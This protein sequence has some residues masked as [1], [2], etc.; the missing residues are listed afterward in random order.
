MVSYDRR[1]WSGRWALLAVLV[2]AGCADKS[3]EG[4]ADGGDG[5]G[6]AAPYTFATSVDGSVPLTD[7]TAAQAMQF[8]ADVSTTN[9]GPLQTTSCSAYNRAVAVDDTRGYLEDNPGTS[10]ASLQAVCTRFLMGQNSSP[11]PLVQACDPARIA[12]SSAACTATVADVV[13]CI[14]ENAA[15]AQELLNTT[16][17]CTSITASS[18][19]R[20]F[21]AGGAFDMYAGVSMSASCEAIVPCNGISTISGGSP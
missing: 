8:C 4:S 13:I 10:N 19:S 11:C 14:N 12:L 2:Y 17:S 16:P 1:G 9:A 18:L 5:S 6:D 3:I 15:L 20:Y 21:A 7:L